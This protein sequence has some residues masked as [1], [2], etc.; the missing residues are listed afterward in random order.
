MRFKISTLQQV[1][2]EVPVL[3]AK[4]PS[5]FSLKEALLGRRGNFGRIFEVKINQHALDRCKIIHLSGEKKYIL[6]E[7]CSMDVARSGRLETRLSPDFKAEVNM[8][9]ILGGHVA[10]HLGIPKA[11]Y[12]GSSEIGLISDLY[13]PDLSRVMMDTKRFS[14]DHRV[15]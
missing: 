7:C 2:Y 11:V 9:K 4:I 10:V 13:G 1:L 8:L 12:I 14:L 6:K 5:A 15:Y 3:Q